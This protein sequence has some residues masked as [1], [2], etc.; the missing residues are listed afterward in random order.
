VQAIPAFLLDNPFSSPV[1]G[2]DF[3]TPGTFP[4]PLRSGE[5][6]SSISHR[7]FSFPSGA[8]DRALLTT[9]CL[10]RPWHPTVPAH[11]M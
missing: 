8:E 5:V 3:A 6:P 4:E 11:S 1:L 10:A 2:L 7:I 9:R